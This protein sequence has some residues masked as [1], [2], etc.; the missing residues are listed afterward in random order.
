MAIDPD[1]KEALA[2]ALTKIHYSE[3]PPS[4]HLLFDELNTVMKLIKYDELL[5]AIPITPDEQKITPDE[6][7]FID[8][9]VAT[10]RSRHNIT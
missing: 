5:D 6:Q 8:Q 1:T 3:P 7:K 2:E 10:I 4:L 9:A